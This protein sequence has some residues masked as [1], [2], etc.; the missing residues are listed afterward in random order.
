VPEDVDTTDDETT[1]RVVPE[2]RFN[3]IYAQLQ[4]EKRARSDLES[5]LQEVE[6]RDKPEVARLTKQ[7]EQLAKEREQL[8]K[9][10]DSERSE[11]QK[12]SRRSIVTE[13][14]AKLGFRDPADAALFVDLDTIEDSDTA[15]RALKTVAKQR[16][17]LIA[18]KQPEPKGLDRVLAASGTGTDDGSDEPRKGVLRQMTQEELAKRAEA[19]TMW[20]VMRTAREREGR[21]PI[22]D[23][24]A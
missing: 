14:A 4:E 15:E 21:P 17:Y 2:K 9:E 24:T 11:R 6:D 22:G 7:Y 20:E 5:R 3:K 16:D 10:L 23:R 13:A 12:A 19:E 18:P 8:M 1:D